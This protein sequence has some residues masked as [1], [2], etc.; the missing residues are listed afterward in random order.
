MLVAITPWS[1]DYLKVLEYFSTIF[2]ATLFSTYL[3]F[4]LGWNLDE[5]LS[6]GDYHMPNKGDLALTTVIT[7]T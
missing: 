3:N 2:G 1:N 5:L 6:R 4:Y 7:V